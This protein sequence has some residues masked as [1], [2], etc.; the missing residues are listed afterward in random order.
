MF[1]FNYNVQT[2]VPTNKLEWCDND[3]FWTDVS[4]SENM[5]GIKIMFHVGITWKI[6]FY[7]SEMWK[8][9]TKLKIQ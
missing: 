9:Y 1:F 6:I 5:F 7:S 3:D 2:Y 8:L 4:Y